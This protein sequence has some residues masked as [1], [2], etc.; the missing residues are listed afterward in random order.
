MV[1]RLPHIVDLEMLAFKDQS[2]QDWVNDNNVLM[3]EL[4]SD[5]AE[6]LIAESDVEVVSLLELWFEEELVAI[7]D[8][9]RELLPEAL[10]NNMKNWAEREEY[11]RAARSRDILK[12]LK[13]TE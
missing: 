9:N 4:V 8:L 7:I 3:D 1:S 11:V 5:A 12:K 13:S 2:I 6:I 10:E